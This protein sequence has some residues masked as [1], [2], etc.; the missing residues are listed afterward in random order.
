MS[1]DGLGN[2]E[3]ARARL[4]ARPEAPWGLWAGLAGGLA[5]AALSVK[6]ILASGS[7]TAAIG[8][9][10]VPFVAI[11]AMIPS[12][13][14]GLAAGCVYLSLRG[15]QQYAPAMLVAAWAFA[16]A[17]PAA[18]GWEAWRGLALERAVA[19]ARTLDARHLDDLYARSPWNRDKYFL[20]ALV[21]REDAG[22]ALLDR[23]AS[24]EDP[25]LYEP[26]G[27]LWNVMGENR[28]GIAVMRLVANHAHASGAT[29]ARLAGGPHAD[30]LRHELARNPNT[31]APLLQQW[32]DSTDYLVEWGLALNPR[33]P[34][35]VMERLARSSNAYTRLNLTHNPA[36]PRALLEQLAQDRD[37]SVARYAA[38]A[39]QRPGR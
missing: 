39:L 28:K 31:P 38:H 5:A 36:T 32:H 4:S 35:G 1:G 17:G 10:F 19:E 27:S 11:A 14:W 6:G 26:M 23:I 20:G 30:K 9:I 13:V 15:A 37:E 21:Q 2:E 34:L 29:L 3:S 22:P 16:L 33:T 7:S 24:L 8:F 18:I 25:E 12:A